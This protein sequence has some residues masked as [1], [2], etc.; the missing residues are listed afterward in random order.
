MRKTKPQEL[1]PGYIRLLQPL[2]GVQQ[3]SQKDDTHQQVV[4]LHLGSDK[5]FT[6]V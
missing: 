3:R 4:Q 5:N 6:E 1:Q 2:I